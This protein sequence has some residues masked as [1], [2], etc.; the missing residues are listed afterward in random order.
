[1]WKDWTLCQELSQ[2]TNPHC[3]GQN[4]KPR[5][6]QHT[7][8]PGTATGQQTGSAE[9]PM[10]TLTEEEMQEVSVMYGEGQESFQQA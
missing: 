3:G 9:G 7:D 4:G 5:Q 10:V 6:L 1:M 2:E 8:D